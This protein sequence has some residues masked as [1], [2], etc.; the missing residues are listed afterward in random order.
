MNRRTAALALALFV[1]AFPLALAAQEG[2]GHQAEL[3]A[4]H[5]AE[6]HAAS[7]SS[8]MLGKVINFVILFGALGYFL[9]K[10]LMSFLSKRTSDIRASLDEARAAREKA[11]RKLAETQ[12]RIASLEGEAARMKSEA[13]A[14]G[15]RAREDIRTLSEREAERILSLSAQEIDLRVKAGVQELKERTIELAAELAAGRMNKAID[16][17]GHSSLIDKSIEDLEHFNE[18]SDPR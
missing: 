18:K 7:G 13:E 4:G 2:A 11:E 14:E 5:E 17:D 3:Q 9:Y 15:R 10:P 12:T 1:L 6:S 16:A 8:G